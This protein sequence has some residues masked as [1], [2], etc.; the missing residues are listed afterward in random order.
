V[1]NYLWV[2]WIPTRLYSHVTPPSRDRAEA[3]LRSLREA[4]DSFDVHQTSVALDSADY[5]TA[6]HD[7]LI[8]AAIR[9]E[10]DTGEILAVE[11]RGRCEPR[12]RFDHEAGNDPV[13]TARSTLADTTGVVCRV[14]DLRRVSVLSIHDETDAGRPAKFALDVR[15]SGLYE[16]GEPGNGLDWCDGL[17]DRAIE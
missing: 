2:L 15:L 1:T 9:V 16:G 5:D 17:D 4:Y 10:N 12:V 8:D 14:T 11:D 3:A 13:E 7:G 6:L